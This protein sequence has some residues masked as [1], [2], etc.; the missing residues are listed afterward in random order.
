[1]EK[2]IAIP[3]DETETFFEVVVDGDIA[4]YDDGERTGADYADS[5]PVGR[6]ASYL[7]LSPRMLPFTGAVAL[8]TTP[9]LSTIFQH[10]PSRIPMRLHA[11]LNDYLQ[12]M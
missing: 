6:H 8:R 2:T 11:F 3:F 1:M 5:E 4:W 12:G 10:A 9:P 7:R